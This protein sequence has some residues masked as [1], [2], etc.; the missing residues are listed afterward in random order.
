M[1]Y[2][3]PR[4]NCLDEAVLAIQATQKATFT[5]PDSKNQQN[6]VTVSAYE[7]DE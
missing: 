1:K 4:I 3:K 5:M 6:L 2:E 7:A